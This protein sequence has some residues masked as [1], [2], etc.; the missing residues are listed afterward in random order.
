M[1]AFLAHLLKGE[2]ILF[3]RCCHLLLHLLTACTGIDGS[4]DSLTDDELGELLL[5]HLVQAIDTQ[6]HQQP[7]YQEDDFRV[8]HHRFDYSPTLSHFLTVLLC[9]LQP[10]INA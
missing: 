8:H 7:D 3:Q 2:E 5:V 9:Q 10:H 1:G 6:Y 4:D